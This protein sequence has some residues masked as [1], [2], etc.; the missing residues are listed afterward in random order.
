[1]CT[2]SS[3]DA[4]QASC[5]ALEVALTVKADVEVVLYVAPGKPA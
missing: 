1:M 3:R 4:S 5:Y 2:V